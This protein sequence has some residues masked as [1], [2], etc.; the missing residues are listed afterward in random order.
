MIEK[1][2]LDGKALPILPCP[3][4]CEIKKVD[5]DETQII[6]FFEKDLARHESIL[7]IRPQTDSLIIRYHLSDADF[8]TYKSIRHV[9][10]LGR[11]FGKDGYYSVDNCE[12]KKKA[13]YDLN[14]LDHK[15]NCDSITIELWSWD[16]G[17]I[18]IDARVD[19]IEYEWIEKE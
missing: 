11:R 4:D 9:T 7:H 14:Y 1:Y 8:F 16:A 19:S 5:Y 10:W 12:L 2:R 18:I 17:S 6:L 13:K 3:H 15:V